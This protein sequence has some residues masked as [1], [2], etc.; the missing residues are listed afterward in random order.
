MSSAGA[1]LQIQEAIISQLHGKLCR[2]TDLLEALLRN[3]FTEAD[4]RAA[5]AQLLNEERIELTN[6][7]MLKIPGEVAA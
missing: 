2:P 4:I 5:V 3:G 6:Q 7:R 1:A